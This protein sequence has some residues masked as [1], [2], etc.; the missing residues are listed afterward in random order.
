MGPERAAP[1]GRGVAEAMLSLLAKA[2]YD[3]RFPADMDRL[4]CGMAFES[5]GFPTIADRKSDELSAELLQV[6]SGGSVPVLCDTSPCLHRMRKKLDARLQLF[7]PVEFIHRFLMDRLVFEKK[8]G[9]VAIHAPCSTQ[10]MGLADTMRA[11][12]QACAERVIVPS[13]ISCCGFA[14]D[15]GFHVPELNASALA[16]LPGQLP[17]DCRR[18]YSNSR[19]CEIGLSQHAGIPY[20]SIVHLVDRCTRGLA[21]PPA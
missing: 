10:K 17:A 4:C 16:R 13:G 2:G 18:G 5:K 6:T 7:E 21:P 8:E 15:K 12:A 19:T 20:Q 9:T 1:D 11:V 14:G 3:V